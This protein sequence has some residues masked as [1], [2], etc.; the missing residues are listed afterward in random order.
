MGVLFAA[1]LTGLPP[2]LHLWIVG[3]SVAGASGSV[4]R[5]PW[6]LGPTAAFSFH[7][8]EPAKCSRRARPRPL[9]PLTGTS[10]LCPRPTRT[11]S[12]RPCA[13]GPL[14]GPRVPGRRWSGGDSSPRACWAFRVA[15]RRQVGG[16]CPWKARVT[17]Q[18]LTFR[19][20]SRSRAFWLA[21]S[22]QE[23]TG[24]PKVLFLEFLPV[25]PKRDN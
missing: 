7:C 25:S 5:R 10:P 14:R 24:N 3:H 6:G 11:V 20:P 22:S 15:G 21:Y 16:R 18:L 17:R 8:S 4:P 12:G 2:S 1:L 13:A 9:P 23:D 19:T